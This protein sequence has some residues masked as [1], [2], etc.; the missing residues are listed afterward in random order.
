MEIRNLLPLHQFRGGQHVVIREVQDDN[1]ERLKHW[2]NMGFVPATV[3]Q[4]VSYQPLD[5]LFVLKIGERT[6]HVG[7]EGIA[8]LRG[9]P[10]DAQGSVV[11]GQ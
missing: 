2:R 3:V 1:P 10:V 6:V 11:G 7:S 5:D 9:E 4:F 8:G